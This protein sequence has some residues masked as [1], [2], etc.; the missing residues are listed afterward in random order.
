MSV[1]CCG[2]SFTRAERSSIS[3]VWRR[4]FE[5]S[6][7]A[8][9]EA[10]VWCGLKTAPASSIAS[11]GEATSETGRCRRSASDTLRV[12]FEAYTQEESARFDLIWKDVNLLYGVDAKSWRLRLQWSNGRACRRARGSAAAFLS[13]APRPKWGESS[14][15]VSQQAMQCIIFRAFTNRLNSRIK[16]ALEPV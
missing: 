10:S 4:S 7:R 1:K 16:A 6:K 2:T 9:L 11:A 8:I 15:P 13:S 12:S 14:P 3:Y 5:S